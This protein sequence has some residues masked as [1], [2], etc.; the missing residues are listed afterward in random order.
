MIRQLNQQG[1]RLCF[2]TGVQT[3]GRV[4]YNVIASTNST[5]PQDQLN[6]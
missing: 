1:Y 3:G 6:H 2:A 5:D 4:N